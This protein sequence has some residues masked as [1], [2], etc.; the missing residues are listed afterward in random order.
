MIQQKSYMDTYLFG[1]RRNQLFALPIETPA[2][3]SIL[4]HNTNTV[5]A[6]SLIVS[7]TVNRTQS[8]THNSQICFKVPILH[9]NML[10]N[11]T[12][13][14]KA[15]DDFTRKSLRVGEARVYDVWFARC[16]CCCH[17]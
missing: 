3:T 2:G 4:S 14:T 9:E 1:I 10:I 16:C 7:C 11:N 5:A 15:V 6:S 17:R 12:E 8:H 13:K